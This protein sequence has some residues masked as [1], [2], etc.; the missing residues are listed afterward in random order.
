MATT[1]PRDQRL[2]SAK[3]ILIGLVVLGHLLEATSAWNADIIRLPLTMIYMFH[4]PAFVFLAGVTAKRDN[5]PRR[6][7]AFLV[8]LLTFQGLYFAAVQ[9]LPLEREFS[10]VMPFWILWFLLGMIW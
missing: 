1:I 3:G 6:I 10:P 9:L 4:M 5:L 2:D 8:L 7:G